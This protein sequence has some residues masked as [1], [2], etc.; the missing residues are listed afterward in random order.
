VLDVTSKIIII[1]INS[2]ILS[3]GISF[4]L[5][6]NMAEADYMHWI[7]LIGWNNFF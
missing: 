7:W 4:L 3:V 6:N 1:I 5:L 2:I